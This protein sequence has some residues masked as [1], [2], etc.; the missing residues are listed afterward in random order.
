MG[1]GKEE[2]AQ[3][4][5]CGRPRPLAGMEAR[6]TDGSQEQGNSDP[7]TWLFGGPGDGV[8]SL[9]KAVSVSVPGF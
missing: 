3:R 6:H 8:S 9:S 5:G 1:L 2:V 4:R 7:S